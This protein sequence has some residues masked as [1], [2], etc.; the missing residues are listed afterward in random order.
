MSSTPSRGYAALRRG[1]AS[2]D[3]QVYLVTFATWRRLPWFE[4]F[5]RAVTA[6]RCLTTARNLCASRL[7][8]WVLMPDHWHGMIE[9]GVDD[10]I[11]DIVR[12]LKGH[13][14]RDI[15]LEHRWPH[16]I[17]ADGF[18]ERALRCD[19]NVVAAA[20]YIALNPFRAGLVRRIADYPFWGAIWVDRSLEGGASGL[21]PLPQG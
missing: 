6:A 2:L 1:R 4:D 12:R 21:K 7:L 11:S 16:R 18:H 10:D 17:W 20:R 19:E 13:S 9:L 3:G 15:R 8:A 5:E 14:A